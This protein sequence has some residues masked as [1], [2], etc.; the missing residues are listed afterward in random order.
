LSI[1]VTKRSEDYAK[2]YTDV[3]QKAEMA[4]YGP[5]K[6]TMVIRPYGFALWENI[7][8]IADR[9]FKETGHV[10]AYFPM[11]IPESYMHKEAEH[12]EGLPRNVLSLH[13][14]AEKNWTNRYISVPHLKQSSGPCIK[15]G[16]NPIA[17]CPC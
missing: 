5:V 9:M 7:K 1:S 15:N 2:W 4:D 12:V 13:M 16:S 14:A 6:G 17:I 11:F 10:N 3:V 8:A